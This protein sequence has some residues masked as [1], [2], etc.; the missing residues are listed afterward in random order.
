MTS[1]IITFTDLDGA[2]RDND[3]SQDQFTQE[4]RLSDE[5]E[6]L[7]YVAGLYYYQQNLDNDRSTIV[8][9]DLTACLA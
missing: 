6:K 4:L 7:S 9:E 2:Y 8:G 1:R 5:G 3:A